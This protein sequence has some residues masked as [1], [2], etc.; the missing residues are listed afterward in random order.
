MR[1]KQ[2]LIVSLLAVLAVPVSEA[3]VVR[4]TRHVTVRVQPRVHLAPVTF[5]AVVVTTPPPAERRVWTDAETLQRRDGWTDFT[6]N[7]DRRG[8]RMLLEIDRGA[9]RIDKV[10]LVFDNGDAQAVNFNNA[11]HGTGLYSLIEFRDGRK[12]DHVRVIAKADTKESVIR[13]HLVT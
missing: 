8:D 6:M 11:V 12:I 2:A 1:M 4:R 3:R 9:A 7:V 13:L 5:R 10:E